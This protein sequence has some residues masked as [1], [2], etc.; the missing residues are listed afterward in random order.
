MW[1]VTRKVVVS[2]EFKQR[3]TIS[4]VIQMMECRMLQN[5]L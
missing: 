5:V 4:V 1:S 2:K 3:E